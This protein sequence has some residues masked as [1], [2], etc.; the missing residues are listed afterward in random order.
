MVYFYL[1]NYYGSIIMKEYIFVRQNKQKWLQYER[2]MGDLKSIPTKRLSDMYQDI[3]ADLAYSQS[4]FPKARVTVYLNNLAL[5]LHDYLYT[6][7][8]VDH[9]RAILRFF[10]YVIPRNVA[11][12]HFEL[13][14]S[15][16][17]FAAF[18]LV[19][20]ILAYQDIENVV[21]TL[22]YGYVQMT[23]ENIKNG[24]PTDV[25]GRSNESDMFLFIA[26]NNLRVDLI[27]YSYGVIPI[28]GPGYILMKNGI[29]LG[30]FQS[31]FFLNGVGLQSMTAIWIHGTIEISTIIIGGAAGF[32]LGL[33]WVFPGTYSRKEALKR[34]GLRSVKII[35]SIL[36][37]TILA[38]FFESFLTRHTEYPLFVKLTI[39]LGSLAFIV[40]YYIVLPRKIRKEEAL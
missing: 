5:A 24:V 8:K 37:L 32:A 9:L 29:M 35:L 1:C 34:S 22:G 25:Y 13:K 4:L 28:L 39:I 10:T 12:A 19:G 2:E 14:L 11:D 20:V 30:E 23:L 17:I 3:T 15:F 27:T 33:G 36:P 40:Y 31:L 7:K 6:P 21:D 38:A 16:A 26:L 18:T